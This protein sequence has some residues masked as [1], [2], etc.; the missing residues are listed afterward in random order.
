MEA[1]WSEGEPA[2]WPR[3]PDHPDTHPL[4]AVVV[5]GTAVWVCPKSG[6][7]RKSRAAFARIGELGGMERG[8]GS[9]RR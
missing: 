9:R 4:E 8:G 3:C 1:L 2:V 6:A 7:V 5:D